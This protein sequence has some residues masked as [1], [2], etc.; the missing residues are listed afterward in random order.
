M[1]LSPPVRIKHE[2]SAAPRNL[3]IGRAIPRVNCTR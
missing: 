1:K 2:R 3:I